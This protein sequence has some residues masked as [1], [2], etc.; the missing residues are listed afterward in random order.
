MANIVITSMNGYIKVVFN[1]LSSGFNMDK[2]Y[3]NRN[4]IAEVL[5][6]SGGGVVVTMGHP[7][8]MVRA[9]QISYDGNNGS[10]ID[11]VDAVAP[12]SDSDLCD[13]IGALITA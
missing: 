13:K 10:T 11:T 6:L 12:T 9:Y 1:D 2:G 3:F 8:G 5:E 7:H 4:G